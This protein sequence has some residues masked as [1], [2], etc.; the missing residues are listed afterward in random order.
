[1]GACTHES[2]TM[3]VVTT[4]ATFPQNLSAAVEVREL[5]VPTRDAFPHD[6]AVGPDGMLWFTEQRA[7]AIGSLDPKN[8]VFREIAVAP[9]SSPHGLAVGRDGVVWFTANAKGYI[10]ELHPATGEIIEHTLPDAR[11]KDPHTI[12][13]APDGS[14]WFTVEKSGFVGKL[15]PKSGEF[16]LRPLL[17]SGA[18]PYGIVFGKDGDAYVCEFGTNQIAQISRRGMFVHE[19]ALAP[20]AR[21]RRVAAAPDG[22]LYY[23]D[24]ARGRLG[25]LDPATGA[26]QEWLTP[27]GA[28]SAPY[29]I[30]VG[31]DGDV[32]LSESA[33]KPSTL[34]RFHPDTQ[35]FES[36]KLP[37]G[38][39]VRNMAV[40]RDGHLFFASSDTDRVYLVSKTPRIALLQ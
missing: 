5:R 9:E 22:A 33:P 6:V 10:G 14:L 12:V 35:T 16:A 17:R 7:D 21:P 25:R 19:Y 24:F 28:S 3:P 29:A 36:M 1:M 2:A 37:Y 30:A 39:V 11:A 31:R 13:F 18:D 40:T 38:G 26:S 32:W 34:V 20:G 8:G 27:D 4:A 15:D 23:T